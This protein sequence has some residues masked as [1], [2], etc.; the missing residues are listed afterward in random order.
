MSLFFLVIGMFLPERFDGV[1]LERES[2]EGCRERKWANKLVT[3]NKKCG[4][5][6][7][8]YWLIEGNVLV[9]MQGVQV[10]FAWMVWN[11][12]L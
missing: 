7:N 3:G 12:E 9:F 4:I 11:L 6:R 10:R 1:F 5:V 2:G 8:D